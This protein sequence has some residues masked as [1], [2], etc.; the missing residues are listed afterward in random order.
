M[1]DFGDLE[2][3]R[4]YIS[5]SENRGIVLI[6]HLIQLI[7]VGV[8]LDEALLNISTKIVRRR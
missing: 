6:S 1:W 5:N 7:E 3:D 8:Y 4:E 2:Q